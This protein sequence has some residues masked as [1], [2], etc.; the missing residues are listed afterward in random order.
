ASGG[1]RRGVGALRGGF[2]LDGLDGLLGLG[3]RFGPLV[4]GGADG[5]PCG[6]G[7]LLLRLLL[8]AAGAGAVRDASDAGGSSEGLLMVGAGL[9][10][11]VLGHSESF[12]RGELL[13][14]GLPV[15]AGSE[16]R[17]LL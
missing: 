17:R 6:L 1:G 4:R 13:E 8:A 5:A 2:G 3:R 16:V 11:Q 7:C 9:R 14:A 15:Q 10:D 12:G